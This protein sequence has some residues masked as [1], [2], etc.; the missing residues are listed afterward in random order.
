MEHE[1]KESGYEVTGEFSLNFGRSPSF[2]N[3]GLCCSTG[4]LEHSDLVQGWILNGRLSR[5]YAERVHCRSSLVLAFQ[6]RLQPSHK[7]VGRDSDSGDG[8]DDD[9][10][11]DE[12]DVSA[13]RLVQKI[14]Q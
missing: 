8:N 13:T 9:I 2:A 7:V 3:F 11:V 10:D 5:R 6:H 1:A 14:D 4:S 12:E